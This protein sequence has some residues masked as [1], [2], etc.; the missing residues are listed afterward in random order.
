MRRLALILVALLAIPALAFIGIGGGNSYKVRAIFDNASFLATGEQVKVAGAAVGTI[1]AVDLTPQDGRDDQKAVITLK[2]D[3]SR[4]TPFHAD[5]K[6]TIRA[7]GLLA[8]KFV[9]CD[10]GTANSPE[11]PSIASGQPGAGEHLLP[12][13]RTTT[14]VDLDLVLDTYREP[15]GQEL[16]LLLSELGAGLAGRGEDLNA[17]IHRSAPAFQQTDHVLKILATQNRALA[18]FATDADSV[19][20]AFASK[21]QELAGFITNAAGT[22]QATADRSQAIAGSIER[23]P[24]F[25]RQLRPAAADL[26][27]LTQEGTPVLTQL[28][29][30][31]H[32]L[33]VAIGKLRPVANKGIPAVQAIGKLTDTAGPDLKRTEPLIDI[34]NQIAA[35]LEPLGQKL[36]ALSDALKSGDFRERFLAVLYNATTATN[37]FDSAG[38]YARIEVLS[39]A[40]SEYTTKGFA[41]CDA[42]WGGQSSVVPPQPS[43]ATDGGASSAAA[44]SGLDQGGSTTQQKQQQDGGTAKALLDFLLGGSGQ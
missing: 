39:S 4:F 36:G 41:T 23:L 8:V 34:A 7:E 13:E 20:S 40:C 18:Q 37:G 27:R 33:G 15:A 44:K 35:P 12:V 1:D 22:M 31:G 26:T 29:Q 5:A 11:L 30:S 32:D 17:V 25:L 2:I 10:P 43:A 38:H 19:A 28:G 16:S 21:R 6:C 42:N 9:E 24:G 14:P 3:D